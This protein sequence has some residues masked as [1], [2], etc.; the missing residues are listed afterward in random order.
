MDTFA[1]GL[2]TA[3]PSLPKE[4]MKVAWLGW[5]RYRVEG[6]RIVWAVAA[7]ARLRMTRH[8]A[9]SKLCAGFFAVPAIYAP[10]SAEF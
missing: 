9:Q 5:V 8:P 7:A 1:S 2:S 10:V 6:H 4:A 3:N